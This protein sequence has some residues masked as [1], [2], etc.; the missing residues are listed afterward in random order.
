MVNAR[1]AALR[2]LALAIDGSGAI[3]RR[4]LSVI[5]NDRQALSRMRD[6]GSLV[7]GC[8]RQRRCLISVKLYSSCEPSRHPLPHPPVPETMA[9]IRGKPL[10]VA[11][12]RAYI[13]HQL[14][15]QAILNA[16][17]GAEEAET[18]RADAT[19]NQDTVEHNISRHAV[20]RPDQLADAALCLLKRRGRP[21][22]DSTELTSRREQVL[23]QLAQ[24]KHEPASFY[25]SS[26]ARHL[27]SHRHQ[28]RA[29]SGVDAGFERSRVEVNKSFYSIGGRGRRAGPRHS[30]SKIGPTS[31]HV[32]EI[33]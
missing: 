25:T 14:P 32:V 15:N 28:T 27:A 16:S 31:C 24:T 30:L 7:K 20:G 23:G 33:G 3:F 5:A 21:P 26:L 9:L 1:A 6:L 10:P 11:Y 8:C 22:I 12:R 2:P 17:C 13:G 4:E 29:G 18:P 19:T